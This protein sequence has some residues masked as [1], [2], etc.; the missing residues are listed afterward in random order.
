MSVNAMNPKA[1][2]SAGFD[3]EASAVLMARYA[4]SFFLLVGLSDIFST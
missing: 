1:A 3:Q 4:E 2:L